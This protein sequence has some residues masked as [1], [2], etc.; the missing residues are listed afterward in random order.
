MPDTEGHILHNSVYIKCPE[1]AD[2]KR[3]M[4][5]G[6]QGLEGVGWEGTGKGYGV[7]FWNDENL[8]RLRV[9]RCTLL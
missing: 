8:L 7:S 9:D 5:P 4:S 6:H 3:K 2:P 1:Q